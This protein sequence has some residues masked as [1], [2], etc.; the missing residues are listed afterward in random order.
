[1]SGRAVKLAALFEMPCDTAGTDRKKKLQENKI[2][3]VLSIHDNAEPEFT[4]SKL[5]PCS[6]GVANGSVIV[7]VCV[8]LVHVQVYSCL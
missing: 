2:T 6:E 4:V 3:H 8:G 5:L 1:M 7:F